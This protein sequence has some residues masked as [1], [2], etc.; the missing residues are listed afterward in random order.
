ML[1]DGL[2]VEGGDTASGAV[3]PFSERW[4]FGNHTKKTVKI[5]FKK[6]PRA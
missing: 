1:M 3:S 2:F 6:L 4:D 5:R